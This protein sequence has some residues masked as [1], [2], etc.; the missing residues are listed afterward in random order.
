MF[1]FCQKVY[2]L[3]KKPYLTF[4]NTRERMV[5]GGRGELNLCLPRV[6]AQVKILLWKLLED[7]GS[8]GSLC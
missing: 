3:A 6:K 2:S 4:S 5:G 8:E 7:K 1:S